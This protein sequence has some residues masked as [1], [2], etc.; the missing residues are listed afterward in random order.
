METCKYK[1]CAERSRSRV[2]REKLTTSF[3]GLILSYLFYL[4][5]IIIYYARAKITYVFHSLP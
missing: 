2:H 5:D 4:I 3:Y 1:A